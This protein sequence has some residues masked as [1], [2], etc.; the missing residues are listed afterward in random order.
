MNDPSSEAADNEVVE[1]PRDKPT[2][3]SKG[4]RKKLNLRLWL[5]A[6]HRDA[7]VGAL[8]ADRAV[9]VGQ[10]DGHPG[11]GRLGEIPDSALR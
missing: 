7:E 4:E 8:T 2:R 6:F 1:A 10:S 11:V 9:G 3:P 5:R